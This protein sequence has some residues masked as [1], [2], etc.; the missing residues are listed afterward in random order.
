M[1]DYIQSSFTESLNKAD[2]IDAE[3]KTAILDKSNSVR[4]NIGIPDWVLDNDEIN[5]FYSEVS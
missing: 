5:L 4:K 2:W 3:T 1:I